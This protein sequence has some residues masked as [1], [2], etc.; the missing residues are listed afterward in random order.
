METPHGSMGTREH[1]WADIPGEGQRTRQVLETL[2]ALRGI[3][4]GKRPTI[5][6][7][8]ASYPPS[9]RFASRFA[10]RRGPHRGHPVGDAVAGNQE[11]DG[12]L[13]TQNRLDT[14]LSV[15]EGTALSV[16]EGT[17]LSL[18]EG[19][20]LSVP[21]GR[22][23]QVDHRPAGSD[24]T[25]RPPA[26]DALWGPPARRPVHPPSNP[27]ELRSPRLLELVRGEGRIGPFAAPIG[28]DETGALVWHDLHSLASSHLLVCAPAPE[29]LEA[30]RTVAA[31]LALTTRP[32]LLQLLTIDST[33]REL[34]V[35]ENLPHAL[36][37][38]AIDPV[39]ATLSLRWLAAELAARRREGRAWPEILLVI[40][41][42]AALEADP[43]RGSRQVLGR[44]VRYGGAVGIRVAAGTSQI[45]RPWWR[46]DWRRS[47]VAR[48]T[49][50][51]ASEYTYQRG[52]SRVRLAL[53]P[54][55]VVDLDLL[56]R[57]R[58]AKPRSVAER[59]VAPAAWP[60]LADLR[61]PQG[62][63]R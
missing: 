18:L 11:G 41:D 36:A 5:A 48:I 33:G 24:P 34:L 43:S 32:A 25:P 7:H 9:S 29:R 20:A 35:L 31:G 55:P 59:G 28:V 44:L 51:D 17:A 38:T 3:P 22:R 46:S 30:L 16:P 19:T 63:A 37:Q 40:D 57:G 14:A 61:P 42:L 45:P 15:P 13:A 23:R 39:D 56:A 8:P 47:D 62:G 50:I 12:S 54:L 49:A 4:F 58:V 21:E 52:K 1:H 10:S 53:A 60:T 2:L 26:Q 27:N 6:F